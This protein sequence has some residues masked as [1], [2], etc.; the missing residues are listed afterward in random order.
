MGSKF[1]NSPT[2]PSRMSKNYIAAFALFALFVAA[3]ADVS[4]LAKEGCCCCHCAGGNKCAG[5]ACC[6]PDDVCTTTAG[7]VF[8]VRAAQAEALKK[9]EAEQASRRKLELEA[10]KPEKD[11]AKPAATTTESKKAATPKV[12]K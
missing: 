1:G 11:E 7:Q 3:T 2:L 4:C 6:H 8:D 10:A 5:K 12:D 9:H